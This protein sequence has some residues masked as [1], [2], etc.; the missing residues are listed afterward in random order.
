METLCESAQKAKKLGL[1]NEECMPTKLLFE[2]AQDAVSEYNGDSKH[3]DGS[4]FRAHVMAKASHPF[5]SFISAA[6]SNYNVPHLFVVTAI[7]GR[8]CEYLGEREDQRLVI[9]LTGYMLKLEELGMVAFRGSKEP[10][11]I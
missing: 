9:F 3:S 1:I 5:M 4:N 2:M 6:Y 8:I 11:Q 10:R 7:C